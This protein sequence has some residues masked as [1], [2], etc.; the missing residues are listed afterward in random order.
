MAKP[1]VPP[2]VRRTVDYFQTKDFSRNDFDQDVDPL[3]RLLIGGTYQTLN[4]EYLETKYKI[5]VSKFIDIKK[6]AE[7]EQF[8]GVRQKSNNQIFAKNYYDANRA[9]AK[10]YAKFAKLTNAM[11]V[12]GVD[13]LEILENS[14]L[15][16]QDVDYLSDVTK[17]T[18]Y[19][20]SLGLSEKLNADG[21]DLSF[22]T[23]SGIA[24]KIYENKFNNLD[25][26]KLNKIILDKLN[27]QKKIYMEETHI[28]KRLSKFINVRLSYWNIDILPLDTMNNN[29][30]LYIERK[31]M[32]LNTDIRKRNC[33][34]YES[35]S[36]EGY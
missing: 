27:I 13:T 11:E 15:D 9:F 20:L 22:K 24:R 6:Q 29:I 3:T 7:R 5:E 12:L 17:S 19:F 23:D 2:D 35:G 31:N 28:K 30:D 16:A 1:L 32:N 8:E 26:L 21:T 33:C 4:K 25:N 10:K 36:F 18:I 14:R 34:S